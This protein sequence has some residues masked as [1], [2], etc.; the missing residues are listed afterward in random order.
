MWIAVLALLGGLVAL[1]VVGARALANLGVQP[2][3]AVIALRVFNVAAVVAVVAYA[4]FM[5]MGG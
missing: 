5:W 3:R 4:F 1:Q 2:S